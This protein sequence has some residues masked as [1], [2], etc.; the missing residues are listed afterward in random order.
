MNWKEKKPHPYDGLTVECAAIMDHDR[1]VY[2]VP[3]PGR[4]HDVIRLMVEQGRPKPISG[5]QGFILSDGR[6]C[7]RR[8]ARII[9]EHSGQLLER[10]SKGQLLFSEDVW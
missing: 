8:P 1:T 5:E 3:R 6:F 9:A 2:S 7:R 4:H 10:A